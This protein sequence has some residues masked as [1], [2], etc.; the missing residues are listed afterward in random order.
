VRLALSGRAGLPPEGSTPPGA[1]AAERPGAP[2]EASAGSG[3]GAKAVREAGSAS[4][5]WW[6]RAVTVVA[7]VA[8]MAVVAGSVAT[9]VAP[10]GSSSKVAAATFNA[11]AA[12][13]LLGR[14]RWPRA[15]LGAVGVLAVTTAVATPSFARHGAIL[16]VVLAVYN[17]ATLEVPRTSILLAV[18]AELAIGLS[19]FSSD[20]ALLAD[21]GSAVSEVALISCAVAVGISVRYQRSMLQAFRER[22]EQAEREQGWGAARAV[23]AERVRI[24]R[25]LHDVVAHHVSLLVVQAGAV[26]ETLPY[27]HSTRPVL[28]TMIA[29]GRS[30]MAE[31]REMLGALRLDEQ[32]ASSLQARPETPAAQGASGPVTH[33]ETSSGSPRSPQPALGQLASLVDG[34]RAAGLPVTL[35]QKIRTEKIPPVVSLTAYRIVQEA[36][37][38]VIKHA[39]GAFTAV[40]V[41]C[42]GGRLD[43]SVRNGQP[44]TAGSPLGRTSERSTEGHG[45]VGMAER[46]HLVGGIFSAGPLAASR[47]LEGRGSVIGRSVAGKPSDGGWEVSASLPVGDTPSAP[48]GSEV[49][50]E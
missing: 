3:S 25:E 14:T 44:P 22:A 5:W 4:P 29:G 8:V 10:G 41:T 34:A 49:G 36:L 27:D 39:P 24:A 18:S 19:G 7:W 9:A 40:T 35:D 47:R 16:L 17:A 38:N 26:R 37:T 1:L 2:S 23:A 6:R 48:A 33:Y 11:L 13:A 21:L 46:A 32:P 30:A 12:A 43:L 20:R 42:E 28:D 15:V 45:L 50:D 31:L